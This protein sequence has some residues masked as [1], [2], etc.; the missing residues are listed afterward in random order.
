MKSNVFSNGEAD[1]LN[2]VA[3]KI[4][5][6]CLEDFIRDLSMENFAFLPQDLQT[7]APSEVQQD[8]DAIRKHCTNRHFWSRSKILDAITPSIG[9]S[10]K[11]H[12]VISQV[13][14]TNDFFAPVMTR[15]V[16]EALTLKAKSRTLCARKT[17]SLY[18]HHLTPRSLWPQA[19][20]DC[21]YGR[22]DFRTVAD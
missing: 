5:R 20:H 8:Y 3:R 1:P 4:E 11:T 2:L 15:Y 19:P 7:L 10:P 13:D 6:S 14:H 18:V 22:K 12:S 16:K 9:R 17:L 21:W